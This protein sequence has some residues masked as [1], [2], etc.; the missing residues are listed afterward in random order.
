MMNQQDVTKR[1]LQLLNELE[2]TKVQKGMLACWFLGQGGVILKGNDDKLV[3]VDPYLSQSAHRLFPPPFPASKLDLLDIVC[4]THDH[5]DHLDP[6]TIQAIA[7]ANPN[8]T[9]IAPS[10]SHHIVK[11]CGVKSDKI[12]PADTTATLK[13][14]D[15]CINPIPAAHEDFEYTDDLGHRFVGYLFNWNGLNI[16]HAGDTIVYPELVEGLSGEK[17]DLAFLPINGRDLFRN[18]QG[19]IGNMNLREAAD[20]AAEAGIKTLVPVHY[21]MFQNNAE[22]PG[23]IVDYLYE[24]YPYQ[25]FHVFSRFERFVYVSELL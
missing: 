1:G 21:D 23:R 12:V 13:F 24:H 15:V 10:Y 4:I 2:K 19:I 6:G 8:T 16:Y 25:K 14:G 20:L 7:A 17:I 11:D 18:K 9:F 3:A 5:N 22:W